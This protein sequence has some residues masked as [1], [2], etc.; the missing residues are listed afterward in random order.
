MVRLEEDFFRNDFSSEPKQ[1]ANLDSLASFLRTVSVRAVPQ[2]LCSL[3][4][5][6]LLFNLVPFFITQ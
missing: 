5:L 4:E 6:S 3:L 2:V 1:P